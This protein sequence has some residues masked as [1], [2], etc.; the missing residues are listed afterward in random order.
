MNK[1]RVR[2]LAKDFGM[3]NKDV[4]EILGKYGEAPKSN[5]QALTDEQSAGV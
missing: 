4:M 1:Y 2:E 5:M 3:S